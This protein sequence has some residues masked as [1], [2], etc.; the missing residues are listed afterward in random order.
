MNDTRI[1]KTNIGYYE[2]VDKPSQEELQQRIN[3]GDRFLVYSADSIFL[4]YFSER[5][6]VD[7]K[8]S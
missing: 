1:K 2:V 4:N 6:D 3:E 8:N 7:L 5:P